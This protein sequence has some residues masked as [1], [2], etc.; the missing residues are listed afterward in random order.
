MGWEKYS[1]EIRDKNFGMV[2][3]QTS[4]NPRKCDKI[5]W[6]FKM[7]TNQQIQ[8][9]RSDLLLINLILINQKKRTCHLV[10]LAVPV[11]Y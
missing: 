7:Q 6:D 9:R 3:A 8:A 11:D 10:D 5:L 4:T 1:T 2:Y